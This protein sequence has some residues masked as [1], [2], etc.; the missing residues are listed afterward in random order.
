MRGVTGS[1][2]D[3]EALFSTSTVT[4]IEYFL[5]LLVEV[6]GEEE[7]VGDGLILVLTMGEEGEEE[8]EELAK[9]GGDDERDFC[10]LFSTGRSESLSSIIGVFLSA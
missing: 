4:L 5:A 8:G 7:V 10:A 6:V 9:V 3:A 2:G 1:S